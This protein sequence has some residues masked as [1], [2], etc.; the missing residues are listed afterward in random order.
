MI[1]AGVVADTSTETDTVLTGATLVGSPASYSKDNAIN[2]N[3]DD[4]LEKIV[5]DSDLGTLAFAKAALQSAE[6]KF[7]DAVDEP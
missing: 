5:E 6:Q 1:D 3:I 4:F 7:M 2:V